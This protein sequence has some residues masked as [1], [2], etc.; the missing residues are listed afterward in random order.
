MILYYFTETYPYG[1][2]ESWKTNELSVFSKLFKKIYICPLRKDGAINDILGKFKNIEVLE[3]I[4]SE[5]LYLKKSDIVL[6]F[7]K[8]A[9][10]ELF[11]LGL[12]YFYLNFKELISFLRRARY[13]KTSPVFDQIN[14]VETHGVVW[15]FFWARGWS[16][17]LPFITVPKGVKVFVRLHGYDLYLERN[18]G[19]IP[20]RNEL[21]KKAGLLLPV[22]NV[23]KQYL[24]KIFKVESNKILVSRLGTNSIGKSS[25]SLDNKLRV[26]TCSAMVHVKRIERL[27]KALQQITDIN[28]IWTHIGDGHLRSGIEQLA[29]QLPAN[30]EKRFQGQ[31][32]SENVLKYYLDNPVDL[33]INT[34]ESEGVP[35]AI[36]EAMSAGIPII[37]SNVGGTSEIVDES[38]GQLVENNSEQPTSIALAIAKFYKSSDAQK[39]KFRN[40]AY[41]KYMKMCNAEINAQQ[42][43]K[44][45]QDDLDY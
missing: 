30:I 40:A 32:S 41:E 34:S 45:F 29:E 9:F 20:F 17:V 5:S 7:N 21:F 42:L 27:V 11:S 37:A 3:P 14:H 39:Q 4:F 26:V 12:K 23:G 18:H 10:K 1:L 43:A 16:D 13:I 6:I 28:I 44:T 31:V 38:F 19:Y 36:M 35:V 8:T 15:Y 2:G 33:F 22:S 24:E 25:A